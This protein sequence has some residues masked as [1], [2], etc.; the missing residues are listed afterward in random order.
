MVTIDSNTSTVLVAVMCG[1][2]AILVGLMGFLLGVYTRSSSKK[3]R[4]S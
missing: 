1:F 2:G 4:K 3:D